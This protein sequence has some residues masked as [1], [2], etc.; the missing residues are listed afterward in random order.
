MRPSPCYHAA[1]VLEDA[2][3]IFQDILVLGLILPNI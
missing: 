1:G 3:N 2:Y